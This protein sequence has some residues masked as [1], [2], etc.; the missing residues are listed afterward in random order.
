MY[1]AAV[2]TPLELARRRGAQGGAADPSQPRRRLECLACVRV[3]EHV[4]GPATYR[5]DGTVLVQWWRC[6][7]CNEAQTVG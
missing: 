7:E 2:P 6:A 4:K 3:T 5:E 1:E